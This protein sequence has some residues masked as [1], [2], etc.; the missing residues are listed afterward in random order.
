MYGGTMKNTKVKSLFAFFLAVLF[1]MPTFMG[2]EGKKEDEAKKFAIKNNEAQM[3]Q[4]ATSPG[5]SG[6]KEFGLRF[7]GGA[8]LLFGINHIND[9]YE[10]WNDWYNDVADYENSF[11]SSLDFFGS[12]DPLKFAFLGGL[13]LFF[14]INPYL[15]FGLGV[16]YLTGNKKSGPVGIDGYYYDL[17]TDWSLTI[18]RRFTQKVSAIP[19]NLTVYG[20]IP[21]GSK[22]RIVP[23]FGV[24]LYLGRITLEELYNIDD[25]NWGFPYTEEGSSTWT[26]HSNPTAFGFHGGLNFDI[27]FNQNVGFFVGIGGISASFV[28]ILGDLEWAYDGV[29]WWGNYEDNGTD[30]DLKLWYLEE[31]GGYY[32]NKWYPSIYLTDEDPHNWSGARNV[33]PGKISLSQFRFV[34]GLVVFFSR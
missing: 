9:S 33:E 8:G 13:E 28:D 2:A 12:L 1:L 34:V 27:Y 20:G 5:N 21:L 10:G 4:V 3:P 31:E 24:G 23:Y 16:G 15:G 22:M 30:K 25:E 18:E 11:G 6:G 19:L 17:E 14:N 29:D 26:T 32:P 7:Y